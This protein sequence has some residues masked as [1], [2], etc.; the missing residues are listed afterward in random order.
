VPKAASHFK[1]SCIIAS[2]TT[3][4]LAELVEADFGNHHSCSVTSL[5]LANILKSAPSR[6]WPLGNATHA[7]CA[8]FYDEFG[9]LSIMQLCL[10]FTS[11]Y[12]C[13]LLGF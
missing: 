4:T 3:K 11:Y 13:Q 8:F 2:S 6:L 1:L 7:R 9:L 12:R 10:R 5:S